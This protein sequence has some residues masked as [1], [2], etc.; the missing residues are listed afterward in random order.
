MQSTP[1][2]RRRS[3]APAARSPA[4]P[5]RRDDNVG[6][7]RGA[8]RRRR[9]WWR[10][11]RRWRG[12]AAREPSRWRRSTAR[13]WTSR[14]GARWPQR[15]AHHLAR[16]EVRGVV[17]THGTDTL[18]ETAYFL[19]RVL[20]PAKPVVLTAAMRPATSLAG[21]RAAEPA[22]CG[23]RGAQR[24]ARAA[25]S[26][27]WPARCT[28]RSTCARCTRYRLDAF[29]SGDAGPLGAG[30]GGRLRQLR[31]VAARR[32]ARPRRG[33]PSDAARVA[34]GR[35]RH[36]PRRRRWP[37]RRCAAARRAA[38]TASWSPAPATARCTARSRRR[39]CEAQARAA[40]AVLRSTRC[41]DGA[42]RR[43]APTTRLPSAG[44]LTPVQARV[45]LMLRLLRASRAGLTRRA[46]T[47]SD[48]VER[49][50]DVAARRVRVRADLV[51]GRRPASSPAPCPCRGS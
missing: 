48:D 1:S 50:L 9:S 43:R 45:E 38:S 4:R 2:H 11:C 39:C 12:V 24:R 46:R 7:T 3:S 42:D 29:G 35:D 22:R 37:R 15:V 27:C 40:C 47:G 31:A 8:A 17:I 26:S 23:R 6:Y 49:H 25:W 36:Q 33:L 10:R 18:E 14:S 16:P 28:R 20:A 19:Q 21:R 5:Q 30:R 32:G 34:A 41:L 51:R 44:A 13:T